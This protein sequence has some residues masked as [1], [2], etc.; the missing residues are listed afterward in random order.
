VYVVGPPHRKHPIWI[1]RTPHG[2]GIVPRHPLDRNGQPPIN[3]KNG[4]FLLAMEKDEI[5]ARFEPV[6][7]KGLHWETSLPKEFSQDR[8]LMATATKITPPVIEGR[9]LRLASDRGP[10][11]LE[12]SKQEENEIRYDYKT[13]NFVA[14]RTTGNGA[15]RTIA[16]QPVV[17]AHVGSHGVS[18]GVTGHG[19]GWFG[20]SGGGSSANVN[21]TGRIGRLRNKPSAS[22]NAHGNSS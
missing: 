22:R 2:L 12:T 10:I 17:L 15:G 6:P 19:G 13:R 21:N 7:A 8:I 14:T 5:Q 4:V 20:G 9:I 1:V 18:G 11:T 16:S 3:A